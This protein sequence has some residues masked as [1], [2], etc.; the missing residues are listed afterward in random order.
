VSSRNQSLFALVAERLDELASLFAQVAASSDA[1]EPPWTS[2]CRPA[3]KSRRAFV[4]W[5]REACRRGVPGVVKVGRLWICPR[6][7]FLGALRRAPVTASNDT[8][9]W[10]PDVAFERAGYRRRR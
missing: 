7:A 2:A 4:E 5:C 3:G 1:D 8:D 9:A 10:S 6:K